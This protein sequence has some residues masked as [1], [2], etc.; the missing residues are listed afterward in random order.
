MLNSLTI[1]DSAPK[2]M[3][4]LACCE[5]SGGVVEDPLK[6]NIQGEIAGNNISTLQGGIVIT[7]DVPLPGGCIL[8]PQV[9]I[10]TFGK[11]Y[12]GGISFRYPF[13]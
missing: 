8:S 11:V 1:K 6:I 3:A 4:P 2:R 9:T 13:H 10:D 7:A 12:N 5:V